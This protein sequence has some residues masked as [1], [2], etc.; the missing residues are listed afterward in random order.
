[1]LSFKSNLQH[2]LTVKVNTA[3]LTALFKCQSAWPHYFWE[4]CSVWKQHAHSEG[5]T[6]IFFPWITRLDRLGSLPE[7]DCFLSL[8]VVCTDLRCVHQN[9]QCLHAAVD[10]FR[11][12]EIVRET[13]KHALT[14]I[15][16][17]KSPDRLMNNK[18]SNVQ[19]GRLDERIKIGRQ[20][21]AAISK[22]FDWLNAVFLEPN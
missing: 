1:M 21:S 18:V 6:L 16:Q 22:S 19:S 8:L 10:V 3:L 14:A 20:I 9:S 2:L 7:F 5:R 4:S 11:E 13:P 17:Y 15:V 12:R